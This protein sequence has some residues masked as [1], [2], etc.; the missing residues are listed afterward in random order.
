MPCVYLPG[1]APAVTVA[2]SSILGPL[3]FL[4]YINDLPFVLEFFTLLFADETTLEMNVSDLN[5]LTMKINCEFHKVAEYF[6]ANRMALH[7]KQI[8]FLIFGP[9]LLQEGIQI[10]LNNNNLNDP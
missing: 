3:L 6:R 4:I 8:Q 7:P 5:H 2:N 1:P 10:F 9:N